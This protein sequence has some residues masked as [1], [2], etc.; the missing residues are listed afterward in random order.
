MTIPEGLE[1]FKPSPDRTVFTSTDRVN[2]VGYIQEMDDES[3]KYASGSVLMN[4]EGYQSRYINMAA[5]LTTSG[6]VSATLAQLNVLRDEIIALIGVNPVTFIN[7]SIIELIIPRN[8]AVPVYAVVSCTLSNSDRRVIMAKVNVSA[9]SGAIATLSAGALIINSSLGIASNG[10]G[11]FFSLSNGTRGGHHVIYETSDSFI[12]AGNSVA[13]FGY[14]GGSVMSRYRYLLNKDGDV[15]QNAVMSTASVNIVGARWGGLPGY[16]VGEVYSQDFTTK[17]VFAKAAKTKAEYLTWNPVVA[18]QAKVLVSQE[19][20]QGWIVYFTEN[21]PV[22]INGVAG[23]LNVMNIDLTSIRANASN[24]TFYV[25]VQMVAGEASYVIY[26]HFEAETN[27]LM[28]IGT[29]QTSDLG[30]SVIKVDKVTKFAGFRL[31]I[32]PA[33]SSIPVTVGLPS[34]EG[35]IDSSWIN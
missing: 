19:V 2:F 12:I 17:L 35:H 34:R 9:R 4:I 11:T 31:S 16:G 22:I 25:Y 14:P 15:T 21:T 3:L 33:G 24:W 27:T 20:N 5:D 30:I 26:D 1:G 28:H 13:H 10:T 6:V 18:N 32:T 23:V 7:V 8:P 29:V